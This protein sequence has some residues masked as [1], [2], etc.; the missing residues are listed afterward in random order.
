MSFILPSKVLLQHCATLGKTGK[1]KSSVQ[2]YIVEHLAANK[3]RVCIIDPKGDWWGI[4]SSADGKSA[5]LP[6]VAFGDFINEKAADV[7]INDRSGKEIAQLVAS[8]NR[9]C[10]IG[11]RGW[12]RGALHRF[13]IDFAHALFKVNAGELY[14]II[15]ECH[16]F[17]PKGQVSDDDAGL[18]LHWTNR[19]MSEGRGLGLVCFIAS[20]RPQKVHNDTLTC[21]ETLIAMGV[22]HPADRKAVKDWLDGCGDKLKGDLVLDSLA[23]LERG[24]AYVWSPEIGFGP[25]RIKFPKFWTF[26]SFAPPQLQSRV[27][28]K[29]WADVDLNEVKSKLAAVIEET[30]ANDP[31]ELKQQIA[32]LKKQVKNLTDAKPV[33]AAQPAEIKIKE[34]P[35]FTNQQVMR[36]AEFSGAVSKIEGKLPDL[37]ELIKLAK[38]IG[39]DIHGLHLQVDAIKHARP[40]PA[41]VPQVLSRLP[42]VKHLSASRVPAP[43]RTNL[44][45]NDADSNGGD[46]KL[47]KCENALLAVLAQH[48][49]GCNRKKMILLAGYKWSGSTQSAVSK[50]RSIGAVV[51][52]NS[53]LLQITERGLELGPFDP[54]PDDLK[55]FW[56]SHP[57]F[58]LCERTLLKC[59]FEHPEGLTLEQL[60]KVSGYTWS[61]STQSSVSALR[62]SEVITGRNNE[63]MRL[64]D[65]LAAL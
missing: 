28:E 3:K 21:C 18:C 37:L 27:T 30:K 54:L 20:Q 35:A 1:G 56:L 22:N 51:G 33:K 58:G 9:P 36:F 61:G 47:G 52:E 17:A 62:T 32:E 2:R 48:Q 50:L 8:G 49:D 43:S 10:V 6:F 5:G 45:Q 64:T 31:R 11:L 40:H 7:P 65:E 26:D 15:D 59:F 16:N 53:G 13:W 23:S 55:Q 42:P 44:K 41:P 12:T 25:D 60:L 63:V 4:K 14:L 39:T 46:V 38:T 29:G 19:L 57:S 34:V 24:E